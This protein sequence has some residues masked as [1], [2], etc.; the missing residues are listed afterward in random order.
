MVESE[1]NNMSRKKK[2]RIKSHVKR[3][4]LQQK[5]NPLSREK[6][7][8]A[9]KKARRKDF[10]RVFFRIIITLCIIFLALFT[11]ANVWLKKTAGESLFDCMREAQKIVSESTP[12]DFRMAETSYIYSDDGTQLAGLS[13]DLDATYV[14]YD[15]IP[16]NVV[17]AF[18]AVEDRTFWTNGGIDYKGI[19]RVCLN[20]VKSKGQIKEGASTITQ[21]LARGKFLSN[22]KT[23]LRKVKEIFIA[24][25]LTRKYSKK[26]IMEFYCN[27]CCFANGIYGVEDA[28]QSYFGL[29]ISELDL[30]QTA[31]ICSIPNHPE[32]Y[33]PYY[34]SSNALTRRDK[35]LD[36]MYECGFISSSAKK[37]AEAEKMAVKDKKD[38]E[39][40][41]NYE[42]TYAINCAVRYLMKMD[43]FEFE[44]K[45]S[46]SDAYTEY[47]KLYDEAYKQAKHKLYTGGY[48]ITT[49]INLDAQKKM[50]EVLDEG[51]AFNT[52]KDDSTGVYQLQGAMTVVD[53]ETGKVVAIIGGREQEELK[54]TYSLNRAFQSYRQPGSSFKPIAV[55]APALD[56]G[57]SATS[58]LKNIDVSSAK[59]ATAATISGMYGSS[60]SMRYAV[61]QSKNGCAYWLFNAIGPKKGLSYV[62]DMNFSHIAPSD[63]TLSASLGGL[64]YGVTTVEMANAYA[65]LENHGTYTQT[66]CIEHISDSNGNEIYSTPDSKQVYSKE[67]ADS[68][69]DILMGV[70]KRGTASRL[71]W[72]SASDVDA[73][74]KTG[75]TNDQKDGWFCGYTP[76]YTISVWVGYDTPT[77]MSD[78]WG[79]TYP[80]SIWKEA[81][82]AMLDG[83]ETASFDIQKS[84]YNSTYR[85]YSSGSDNETKSDTKEDTKT[86]D[87]NQ[88]DDQNKTED[89]AKTDENKK[90][91]SDTGTDKK[92]PST[93]DNNTDKIDP[94]IPD[95]KDDSGN[96][97]STKDNGDSS[98]NNSNKD[99][100]DSGNSGDQ[101][102][103][104]ADS[105]DQSPSE[106]GE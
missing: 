32:Y 50:Q 101:A 58:Q 100:G 62:T 18:V 43:G 95:Q 25:E 38:D 45:F 19:V 1:M 94:T 23:M 74:G 88:T 102:D 77:Y 11:A 82:L 24:R 39:E 106:S 81:M 79:N 75:T 80:A 76:Y 16:E 105:A 56:N 65:T 31:Y 2:K 44:S 98:N 52:G 36:D 9:L 12:N 89:P 87:Q 86:D 63:Y 41:Y 8:A 27:T 3:L 21:Q 103:S 26:Q 99:Q 69:T 91:N 92:Q 51:L 22:E 28:S 66:D 96:Q 7:K 93:G 71:N 5:K 57:Y 34:D 84:S 37:E 78:L 13:E 30:S 40:F 33:N 46:S 90:D 17:N 10:F 73:A 97:D 49:T 68:M 6:Y 72:S 54:N 48:K 59:K 70:L 47:M 64:T 14:K 55:Y 4:Q 29:P 53:N 20:Y 104:G 15:D 60:M 67:A 42:V 35:I 83:K 61:E 85:S